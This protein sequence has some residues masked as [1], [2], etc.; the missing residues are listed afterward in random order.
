MFSLLL[1]ST[2]ENYE[3]FVALEIMA[4]ELFVLG[5]VDIYL[6]AFV[7]YLCCYLEYIHPILS[8]T[9]PKLCPSLL[10]HKLSKLCFYLF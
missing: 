1:G 9:N 3:D 6:F 7:M 8:L 2:V 4:V 5:G 10:L